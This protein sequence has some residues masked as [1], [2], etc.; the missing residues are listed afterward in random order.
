MSRREALGSLCTRGIEPWWVRE[1][2]ALLGLSC[3]AARAAPHA[4]DADIRAEA[5]VEILRELVG[6]IRHVSH[7]KI[8][9][10]VLGLEEQYL[11]MSS[12]EER[13]RCAGEAFRGGERPVSAGTIRQ[14]HEKRALDRLTEMLL[15]YEH[16]AAAA[17][18]SP[19]H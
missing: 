6:R 5:L 15:D 11:R 12:A 1:Q 8:L 19:L 13:R 14:H 10:I 7:G 18:H 9:W 3:V 2:E 16:T 4:D 17:R